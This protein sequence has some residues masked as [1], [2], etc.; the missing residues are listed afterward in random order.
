MDTTPPTST[1]SPLPKVGNSLGF[2]VTVTGTVP[3]EPAGSPT[4]DIASFAVY[5][6]TNGGAWTL[7]QNLTPASG[8]PNTATANFTGK[9]NTVYAFY[10][11][12]TDNA[13]NTQAYKPTVEASTDLPDLNTPVTQVA[14][15]STYNGDGTFTLN[16]TG[17]DAGG[18]GLA[19]FEVYVAIGAGTPVLIGPA[20]PAGVANGPGTYQRDD[21]LC[22]A[23]QRLRPVEYL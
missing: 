15:S 12:A 10:S 9:S 23:R 16:L 4:V 14:S 1:V 2:P 11:V 5:V 6:S 7:W 3:T 22:D 13:G 18:S 20:I 8:T 21:H 19:Y 17:T